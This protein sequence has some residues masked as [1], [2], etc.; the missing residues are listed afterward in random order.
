MMKNIRYKITKLAIRDT[1]KIT[2]LFGFDC[3]SGI[4]G[5]EITFKKYSGDTLVN[6]FL[7]FF[8]E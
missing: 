5:F 3:N 8:F 2:A 6:A 1:I 4:F 7:L